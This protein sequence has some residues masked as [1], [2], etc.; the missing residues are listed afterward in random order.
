MRQCIA[1]EEDDAADALG[2]GLPLAFGLGPGLFFASALGLAFG[3]EVDGEE[4]LGKEG[5]F[6]FPFPLAEDVPAESFRG[7][8]HSATACLVEP[9]RRQRPT[10]VGCENV[11]WPPLLQPFSVMKLRQLGLVEVLVEPVEV[12]EA[13]ATLAFFVFASPLHLPAHDLLAQL[14]GGRW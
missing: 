14:Q 1:C 13:T 9:H 2:L 12:K 6:P 10:V 4:L 3:A 11:H 5:L 7:L 8:L